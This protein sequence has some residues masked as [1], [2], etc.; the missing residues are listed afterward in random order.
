MTPATCVEER[1]LQPHRGLREG[2]RKARGDERP[3]SER[4]ENT[5]GAQRN[6]VDEKKPI[7]IECYSLMCNIISIQFLLEI[8]R[9]DS[10]SYSLLD[11]FFQVRRTEP[12]EGAVLP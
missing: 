9:K 10:V 6:R 3:S 7:I 4:S 2:S 11:I 12:L 1:D 8:M 5:R